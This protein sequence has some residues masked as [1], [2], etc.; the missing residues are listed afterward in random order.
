MPQVQSNIPFTCS[1]RITIEEE[2]YTETRICIFRSLLIE[3][4]MLI[5]AGFFKHHFPYYLLSQNNVAV[6]FEKDPNVQSLELHY[7]A[8]NASLL[9]C[10]SDGVDDTHQSTSSLVQ[11][12]IPAGRQ[13]SS[14]DI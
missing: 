10:S 8:C 7:N 9:P 14:E 5:D 3:V 2:N 11:K 6:S 12:T 13:A 4:L 1:N